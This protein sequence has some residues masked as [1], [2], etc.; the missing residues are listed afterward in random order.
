MTR[1]IVI[2]FFP[3]NNTCFMGAFVD[4]YFDVWFLKSLFHMHIMLLA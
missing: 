3:E 1:L 4:A 2:F